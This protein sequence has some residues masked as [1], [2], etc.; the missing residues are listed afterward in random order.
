MI[1][2]LNMLNFLIGNS[3][4][5]AKQMLYNYQENLLKKLL[6]TVILGL[7]PYSGFANTHCDK[8]L[9]VL[10]EYSELNGHIK[11]LA[12]R[13]NQDIV[14]LQ[15]YLKI[16]NNHPTVDTVAAYSHSELD[17]H[18]EKAFQDLKAFEEKNDEEIILSMKE[19]VKKSCK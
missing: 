11:G 16:L 7:L 17:F 1:F 2:S 12:Q 19:S 8:A 4:Y 18:I 13:K 9:N 6:I 5:L 15:G 3:H 10:V 14:L